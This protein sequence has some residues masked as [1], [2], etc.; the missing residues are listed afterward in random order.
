MIS[1][2]CMAK[3][4]L[5]WAT[6]LRAHQSSLA[7]ATIERSIVKKGNLGTLGRWVMD[8]GLPVSNLCT[9]NTVT[10]DR[11]VLHYTWPRLAV[12]YQQTK[13]THSPRD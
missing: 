7:I 8:L 4:R 3:R 1:M 13:L 6:Y 2:Q 9:E 11:I 10:G 5:Q 12:Q